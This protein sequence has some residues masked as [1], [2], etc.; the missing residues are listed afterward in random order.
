MKRVQP[1]I[2]PEPDSKL[3]KDNSI[4]LEGGVKVLTKMNNA[5][6]TLEYALILAVI[7]GALLTMQNYLKRSVQG[8]LAAT[9][10]EI[11]EQYSPGLTS[12][13][14]HLESRVARIGE[15]TQQGENGQT[16]TTVTG[17]H[18]EQNS[19]REIKSL[20][21]EKWVAQQ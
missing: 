20:E 19:R 5:Q 6:S 11:G 3:I 15:I 1:I 14:D 17:G 16:E 13:V 7:V 8:K 9:A 10:D 2:R 21:T 18:Q 4:I 12:K